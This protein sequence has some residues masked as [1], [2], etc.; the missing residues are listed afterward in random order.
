MDNRLPVHQGDVFLRPISKE[1]AGIKRYHDPEPRKRGEGLIL[2]AGEAT[3]HH[4]RIRSR[5]ARMYRS[6][7]RTL[8]HVF[9][10][11]EKRNQATITHEEHGPLPLEPGWWDVSIQ[12][13]YDPVV[14]QRRVYD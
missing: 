7:G 2:A 9:D 5:H 3:G 13:E 11:K 12:R 14:R 6:G 1:E 8:L 4:H 10:C